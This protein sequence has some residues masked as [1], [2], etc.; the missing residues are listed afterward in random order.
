MSNVC[1]GWMSQTKGSDLL[2]QTVLSADL[3]M[4]NFCMTSVLKTQC[5]SY[6]GIE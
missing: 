4:H 5:D 2:Q 3:G 6:F 1:F